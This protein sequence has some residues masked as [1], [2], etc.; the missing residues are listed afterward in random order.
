MLSDCSPSGSRHI[1]K[2]L[3]GHAPLPATSKNPEMLHVQ[4][5]GANVLP[6]L[7]I[8]LVVDDLAEVGLE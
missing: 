8:L 4:H 3:Y 2:S 5:S 7:Y 1:E 6:K